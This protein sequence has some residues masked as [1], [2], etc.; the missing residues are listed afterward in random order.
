MPQYVIER[1]I[2]GAGQ[3]TDQ[4]LRE[5]SL[6]SLESLGQLGPQIQWLHSYVTEDKIYCVYLAPDEATVQEHARR[7]GIPANRVSA[8]R[9]LLDPVNVK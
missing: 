3:L 8:V 5:V 2:A 1:E 6:K 9:R 7:T 4:Q